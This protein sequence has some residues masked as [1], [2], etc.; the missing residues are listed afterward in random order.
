MAEREP[1]RAIIN[2]DQGLNRPSHLLAQHRNKVLDLIAASGATN[3]RVFG[4][5]ARGEDRPNSDIDLLVR[6]DYNNIFAFLDLPNVLSQFLGV[7]VD[8]VSEFGLKSPKHDRVLRE[9]IPL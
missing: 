6:P 8:V 7:P 3:P 2:M 1:E 5:C 4:S 9:A